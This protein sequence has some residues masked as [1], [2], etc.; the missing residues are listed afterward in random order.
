MAEDMDVFVF[1]PP[2]F[3]IEIGLLKTELKPIPTQVVRQAKI[4]DYPNYVAVIIKEDRLH[5]D[6]IKSYT[7][8]FKMPEKVGIYVVP[9]RIH[10]RNIGVSE[11]KLTFE[12]VSKK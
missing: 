9:I 7:F 12:V 4:G 11:H 5:V 10:E 2:V 1:F 3:P 6:A 8:D